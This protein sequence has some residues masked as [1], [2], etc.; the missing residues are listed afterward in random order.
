MRS[1]VVLLAFV[2]L[3]LAAC[4][5]DY[6]TA[7]RLEPFENERILSDARHDIMSLSLTHD[8]R[9]ADLH[10]RLSS[11][12]E[13]VAFDVARA[14]RQLVGNTHSQRHDINVLIDSHAATALSEIAR[15]RSRVDR[16]DSEAR[17]SFAQDVAR[18]QAIDPDLVS[19]DQVAT[20][21]A[22]ARE[23]FVNEELD[24]WVNGAEQ[25]SVRSAESIQNE[26]NRIR[27]N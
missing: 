10:A 3:A 22:S 26:L 20:I 15:I 5:P 16:F 19:A 8:A 23:S 24:E 2:L 12:E 21:I 17:D 6:I 1:I 7:D 4:Q 11:S 18:L 13:K 14:K 27:T 25:A 9:I